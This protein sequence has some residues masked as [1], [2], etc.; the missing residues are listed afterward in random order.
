MTGT[1]SIPQT[2]G[3]LNFHGYDS[4]V[5]VVCVALSAP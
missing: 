4:I 3:G 2:K 5:V 1:Q